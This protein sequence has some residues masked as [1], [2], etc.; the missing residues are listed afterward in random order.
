MFNSIAPSSA[1][2]ISS[3]HIIVA[4]TVGDCVA[5]GQRQGYFFLEAFEERRDRFP[6]HHAA[7]TDQTDGSADSRS[8][9][10]LNLLRWKT[11]TP[12]DP[13]GHK[14]VPNPAMAIRAI[15]END[16]TVEDTSKP[17]SRTPRSMLDQ[18][19]ACSSIVMI[20][21]PFVSRMGC[22][23]EGIRTIDSWAAVRTTRSAAESARPA[24]TYNVFTRTNA[25]DDDGRAMGVDLDI[26]FAATISG[27]THHVS[28]PRT[29]HRLRHAEGKNRRR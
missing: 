4:Q 21:V 13:E 1:D 5:S 16:S 24:Q 10:M 23:P 8:L 25:I 22:S 12:G 17:A 3:D 28:A 15:A 27:T 11:R 2:R 29:E 9:Q 14:P 19:A 20:G 18:V 7:S 6:G 26:Q